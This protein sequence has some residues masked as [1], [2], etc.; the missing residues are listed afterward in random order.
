MA[1]RAS[2]AS[3]LTAR[4]RKTG[5]HLFVSVTSMVSS[6]DHPTSRT[7]LWCLVALARHHGIDLT[8]DALL[9]NHAV[10]AGEVAPSLLVRMARDAT[11][12][13]RGVRLTWADL[14]AL[15]EALPIILRLRDGSY[16][17]LSGFRD[18]RGEPEVVV[19]NPLSLQGGFEFWGRSTLELVWAGDAVLVTRRYGLTDEGRPFGLAW[20]VPEMLRHRRAFAEVALAALVLQIIG[21]ATPIFFQLIIDKVVMHQVYSTLTALGTGVL[22]AIAFDT[23]L[24]YLRTYLML[25]TTA[26]IDIRMTTRVFAHLLSLPLDYFERGA[27]GVLIN[28]VQQDRSIR[29]FLTSRVFFTVLD[30]FALVVFVPFLFLYSPVLA[31][32]VLGFTALVAGVIAGVAG[33]YRR[34]LQQLYRA[35]AARQ[36]LLVETVHGIS[37]VKALSLEPVQRRSWDDRS[38]DMVEKNIEVG[39]VSAAARAASQFLEKSMM[40]VVLWLGVDLV[41]SGGLTVGE[42]VAFQMLASRVTSPM[43]QLVTLIQDYQQAAVSVRMLG[44]VM[45]APPES[46]ASRGLQPRLAGAVTFENVSFRYPSGAAAALDHVNFSLPAGATMGIVGRSGSGKSTLIRL[47]QG[48]YTARDGIVRI[49]GYDLREIDRVHLRRHVGVVLQENFLFRGTVRENIAMSRQDASFEEIVQAA[50]MAGADEFVQR[51]V[52]GY[53]TVLEEGAVNLSGGQ[54]Q[55]LAIARALLRQPA[56]LI[57]DEATSALD[58]ESEAILQRHMPAITRGRTTLVVSHRLSMIR[59][60]DAILVLDQGRMAG[61]GRHD[62]LLQTCAIYRHLWTIQ[63]EAMR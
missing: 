55:R 53:D 26:K 3:P 17:V 30:A 41:V 33:T 2:T 13:A 38:A 6:T 42:L 21:L 54:K 46:A 7:G 51:L 60:A 19:R 56:L 5:G 62:D 8:E 28:H 11:L 9:H 16:V 32:V 39:Q 34:R 23:A 22:I 36:G 57:L 14:N 4:L 48:L 37:T 29:E 25:Q 40:I 49:D 10:P 27:A 24:G 47:V 18:D 59:N 15:G 20:F 58:P 52:K 35:E 44:E 45:N 50:R 63:S 31:L 12:K 61:F 43:M 1:R